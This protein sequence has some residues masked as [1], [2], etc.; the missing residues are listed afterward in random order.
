[1]EKAEKL[2]TTETQALNIPVVIGRC[3]NCKFWERQKDS[4]YSKNMGKC[5]LLSGRLVKDGKEFM[6]KKYSKEEYPNTEKTGIESYPIC[7]HDG[8]GFTYETK[9]WFGCVGYNAL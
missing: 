5:N 1:M 4:E 8:A 7:E 9:E 6:G 2:N 3:F